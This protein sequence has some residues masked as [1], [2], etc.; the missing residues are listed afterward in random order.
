MSKEHLCCYP[1]EIFLD[2][3]VVEPFIC[4]I[5]FGVPYFDVI[6]N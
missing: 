2:Q 5:E 1:E 4:P 6:I 3:K